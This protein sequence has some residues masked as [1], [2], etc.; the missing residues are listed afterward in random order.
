MA[1]HE[2]QRLRREATPEE[3]RVIAYY[4]EL[5]HHYAGDGSLRGRVLP[6]LNQ[7]IKEG[8][9]CFEYRQNAVFYLSL[10][11]LVQAH[12]ID[13]ENV[14]VPMMRQLSS[15]V[16]ISRGEKLQHRTDQTGRVA[17]LSDTVS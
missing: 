3:R 5:V 17:M 12:C 4:S 11:R 15:I 9:T 8:A 13:P 6:L 16:S 2:W 14:L 10:F 7:I 1:D